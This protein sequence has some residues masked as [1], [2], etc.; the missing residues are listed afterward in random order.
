MR[1]RLETFQVDVFEL[2]DHA[3]IMDLECKGS[4]CKK[5]WVL[6]GKLRRQLPINKEL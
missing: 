5:A 6:I 3:R 1:I 4:T 2:D